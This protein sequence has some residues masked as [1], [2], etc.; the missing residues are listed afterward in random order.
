MLK[1]FGVSPLITQMA[2]KKMRQWGFF[3]LVLFTAEA[4]FASVKVQ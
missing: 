4:I 1:D 2:Q 3:I